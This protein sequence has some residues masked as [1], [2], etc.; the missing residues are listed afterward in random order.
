MFLST[1]AITY[2][3]KQLN[4]VILFHKGTSVTN[5][6]HTTI[7]HSTLAPWMG[8][9][10]R[11]GSILPKTEIKKAL[12]KKPTN[13]NHPAKKINEDIILDLIESK[14]VYVMLICL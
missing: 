9:H 1:T 11:L 3:N 8:Q 4:S 7:K 6:Y 5:P 14:K 13:I 12:K 10:T 2:L